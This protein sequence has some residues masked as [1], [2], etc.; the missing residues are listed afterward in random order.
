MISSPYDGGQ[1]TYRDP[2]GI[3]H[4]GQVVG[5]TPDGQWLYI[6]SDRLDDDAP[7]HFKVRTE[8]YAPQLH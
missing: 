8:T 2:V 4:T 7:W 6:H 1:I 3:I 5:Q